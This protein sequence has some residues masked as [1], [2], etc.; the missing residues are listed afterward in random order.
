[1]KNRS[2][3]GDWRI[4]SCRYVNTYYYET[5][6]SRP[7]P[8]QWLAFGQRMLELLREA[9][10]KLFSQKNLDFFFLTACQNL[11]LF[12]FSSSLF[13]LVKNKKPVLIFDKLPSVKREGE[14]QMITSQV[15]VSFVVH[16]SRHLVR[17]G[18]ETFI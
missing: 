1:M 4:I 9:E 12:V 13:F 7:L 14:A 8:V 6:F 5:Y 2:Q 18:L 15:R 3:F 11:V 10:E 17:S 16:D